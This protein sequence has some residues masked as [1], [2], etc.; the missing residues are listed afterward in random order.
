MTHHDIM[1]AASRIVTVAAAARAALVAAASSMGLSLVRGAR[2]LCLDHR[3]VS[4]MPLTPVCLPRLT[5][6]LNT[7]LSDSLNT[8]CS[9]TRP[10]R[11]SF[12][13]G[14]SVCLPLPHWNTRLS[15]TLVV[16]AWVCVCGWVG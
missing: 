9:F 1:A 11:L 2:P 12:R 8:R 16:F 15:L 14:T 5:H 6:A 3:S 7:R 13:I 10:R 4:L